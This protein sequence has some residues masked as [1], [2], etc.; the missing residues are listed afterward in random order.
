MRRRRKR[1]RWS[2]EVD[3]PRDDRGDSR[4]K[5]Q[6]RKTREGG[7]EVEEDGG[8]APRERERE[9][10]KRQKTRRA[11]RVAG[12]HVP[13]GRRSSTFAPEYPH[14]PMVPICDALG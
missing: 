6:R 12:S 3:G 11:R 1:R 9:G 10:E 7:G 5:E 13:R 8:R 2:E 14:P 4:W